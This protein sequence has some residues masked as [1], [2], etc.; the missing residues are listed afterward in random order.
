MKDLGRVRVKVVEPLKEV[1]SG[2]SEVRLAYFK[3]F[4]PSGGRDFNL[5]H[6]GSLQ[7][8]FSLTLNVRKC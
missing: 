6:W 1:T 5:N 4:K 8:T 2:F 3:G 7:P